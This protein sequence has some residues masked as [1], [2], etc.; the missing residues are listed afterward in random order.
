MILIFQYINVV[1]QMDWFVNTEAS[2]DHWNKLHLIM[3]QGILSIYYLI[4][5]EIINILLKIF[6]YMFIN[7]I[8]L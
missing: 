1:Y 3:V 2:L 5:F 6:T 4:Q 7:Y 8:A